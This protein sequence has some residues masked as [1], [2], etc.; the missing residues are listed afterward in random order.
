MQDQDTKL[1]RIMAL[2]I[3][4]STSH[5]KARSAERIKIWAD[6]V[7]EPTG[8][9]AA[10]YARAADNS[11]TAYLRTA[12]GSDNTNIHCD[13]HAFEPDEVSTDA[14]DDENEDNAQQPDHCAHAVCFFE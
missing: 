4:S 1:P 8:R 9:K 6:G 2:L 11:P 14:S 13:Q 12:A 5:S 10:L 7:R 3:F